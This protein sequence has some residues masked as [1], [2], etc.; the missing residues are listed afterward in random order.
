MTD[1]ADCVAILRN[2]KNNSPEKEAIISREGL[3]ILTVA[4][5]T[6]LYLIS[7]S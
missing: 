6:R 3:V 4:N 5:D 2:I 7:E 1:K